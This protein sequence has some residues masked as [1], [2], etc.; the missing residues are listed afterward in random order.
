MAGIGGDEGDD[1]TLGDREPG[2]KRRGCVGGGAG[3]DGDAQR[4]SES[5]GVGGGDIGTGI[6]TCAGLGRRGGGD[7]VFTCPGL[8]G[9]GGGDG[10]FTCPGL[11]R[12]GGGG[13]RVVLP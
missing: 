8:G 6:F 3:F 12:I 11:D 4:F 5:V 1:G 7:D 2:G 9:R 10:I 13:A